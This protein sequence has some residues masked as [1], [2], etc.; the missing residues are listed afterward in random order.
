MRARAAALAPLEVAVRCRGDALPGAAMSGFMP[1]HIEQPAPRQSKPAR[2]RPGR[3]PRARPAPSPAASPG[4][5]SRRR[6]PA[7]VWPST[8]AAAA[9]RSPI[10][11]FVHEPMNTRSSLISWIGVPGRQAHVVERALVLLGA[12]L[13]HGLGRPA[14]TIPGFVP[15][16]TIGLIAAAS[17]LISRSNS[18]PGVGAQLAPVVRQLGRGPR[19]ADHELESGL[20]GRDHPGARRRPRSSCCR[21]SSGLPSRAPRS[22]GRRTR[23]RGR[24]RRRRRSGRSWRGSGPWPS[25]RSR[26]RRRR[27][28]ASTCGLRLDQALGRQHVLDLAG[29]DPERERAERA[30]GGRVRVAA[31]DRHPRLGDPQ[32]RADH[33]DDPLV[34][35]AQRV[36][37]DPELLAVALER[38]APAPA[39][40]RLGS[41]PQR[42]CR[43]SGTLWSAVASV[44]S[45]R[46]TLRPARRRPSNA[47]GLVTSWTRC[48]S[49]YEQAG[50][51]LVGAPRSCRTGVF[52]IV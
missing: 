28:S 22:P 16:V 44:R 37:R 47:C 1:R 34:L 23:R 12:R 17:T 3:G 30:V 35:G 49:M 36:E 48:R 32:L 40:A 31:D 6:R 29:A 19:P 46:R 21:R 5:P 7:T 13:G 45:G 2:R 50:R 10:R 39:R 33:V 51:D 26:A 9:R 20:V 25:R 42:R 11:E 8:T 27:R 4:R 41:A 15:H 38:L 14:T 43:R 24:R 18:A 52:G